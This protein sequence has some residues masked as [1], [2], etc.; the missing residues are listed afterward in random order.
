MTPSPSCYINYCETTNL[1]TEPRF[2][3][4]G[5]PAFLTVSNVYAFEPLPA[6]LPAQ[7][8]PNILGAQ[9]NL[10]TEYVP[11]PENVEFKLFP[12]LCAMAE[13]TWTPA[14]AKNY[15][16]F[17][18]RLVVQQQRLAQMGI[19]YNHESVVPIGGWTQPIPTA[20]TNL[21][22]DIT[23]FVTR[24]GEMDVS[25]WLTSGTSALDIYS[26]ALLENGVQIDLNTFTGV[27]GTSYTRPVPYYILHLPRFHPGA[28]YTLS[29]SVAGDT[30]GASNGTAFLT[31]WN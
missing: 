4:G 11:S 27:S 8:A 6:T 30:G 7:F 12:R 29:A 10:W 14:A 23:S 17:T 3:V 25:F 22:F 20:G 31:N 24:S 1:S 9:C 19:N 26:V 15:N 16:D 18:N 21:T 28:T 2:I 5:T 13:V